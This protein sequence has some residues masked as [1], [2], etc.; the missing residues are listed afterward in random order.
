MI[1]QTIAI[2]V[3]A[4]RDLNSRRMFWI[5]LILSAFVVLGFA[6]VGADARGISLLTY[7]FDLPNGMALYNTLFQSVVIGFWLTW[8][9]TILAIISTAGI[10]PDLIS[11]GSIDLYLAKPISR[12]RLFITKYV[13]G[14]LF[15]TLQ[16]TLISVGSFLALWL[17]GHEWKPRL[18]WAA[19]IVVCFFSYLFAILVLIGV[20]TRSTIA[21]LLLTILCWTLFAVLDHAEPGLLAM[22]DFYDSQARE[23]R[24]EAT[25]LQRAID[26]A[27]RD[28]AMAA[29]LPA[30]RQNADSSRRE[31][32]S[33]EHNA[34]IFR[35][36]QRIA[37]GIK[38]VTPKTTD[39]IGY[40]DTRVFSSEETDLTRPRD[41]DTIDVDTVRDRARTQAKQTD[42]EVRSRSATWIIGTSLLFEAV[43]AGTAM[44]V[45]CRRDY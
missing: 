5:T 21:A 33:S 39:T 28:P 17:R 34:R 8:A 41:G 43:A 19:P 35:L 3:D 32:E 24:D 44:W 7:H 31:A 16:V 10:F 6:M 2:F 14:L 4:Y 45:F 38:T 11:G 18:F 9:A 1:G 37:Y 15:V 40:L 25:S 23:Q 22:R 12:A 30:Y 20:S 13:S 42:D 29:M 27:A 26:R 36:L